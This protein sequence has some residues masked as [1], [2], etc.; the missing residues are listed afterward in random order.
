MGKKEFLKELENRL[1]ILDEKEIKDI[2]SEYR[3]IIE[4]KVKDGK[5]EEEA[6]LEFGSIEEL[7]SE[8]LK[9]YKINPKYADKNKTKDAVKTFEGWVK[10]AA[11]EMSK[12]AK[13]VE[14]NLNDKGKTL[15]IDLVFE[16]LI[17]IV[18]LLVILAILRIPFYII[19]GIGEG[20]FHI[21]FSPIDVVFKI[22][23]W[24]FAGVVYLGLT[25]FIFWT[26]FRDYFNNIDFEKK[27]NTEK[28]EEEKTKKKEIKTE[29]IVENEKVEKNVEIKNENNA[30]VSVL[31]TLLRI[32]VIICFLIP[33]W[34]TEA[35]IVFVLVL[36]VYY[37][38]IG[39]NILGLI[40]ILVGVLI[41]F[42]ALS[43]FIY[44]LAFRIKKVSP[45]AIIPI[46]ISIP[47]IIMGG[48]IFVNNVLSFSY[49]NKIPNNNFNYT[50]TE[51]TF[52]IEKD[53]KIDF[54]NK[55][56]ILYEED[57]NYDNNQVRVLISYPENVKE[58]RNVRLV[59]D[60][61]SYTIK[62]EVDYFVR[63]N[64]IKKVYDL[65]IRDL[66]NGEIYNY[67]KLYQPKITV[68]AN[69]ET[70]ERIK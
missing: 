30:G 33:L 44:N 20:L 35:I 54:D 23:W 66:K 17:K 36:L 70:I 8:I 59:E 27:G 14:N 15:S 4:E 60:R 32:F 67:H 41:G 40:I 2:I 5:K 63:A 26:L 51:K 34:V 19:G 31:L 16:I 18:V 42:S 49:I 48:L 21:S 52:Y 47:V 64:E 37:F 45:L 50:N 46:I 28:K 57:N 69:S 56:V 53:Y 24:V 13:G 58:I 7:C 65:F 38:I 43:D 1:S 25:I 22:V 9:A 62:Y 39:I 29:K 55:A 10:S 61:R 68:I 11:S 12:F 6:V 3:D